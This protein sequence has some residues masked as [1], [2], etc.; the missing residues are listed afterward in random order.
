MD[1]R[2]FRPFIIFVV[3]HYF[4]FLETPKI[5]NWPI[6]YNYH[7]FIRNNWRY[8]LANR[9]FTENSIKGIIFNEATH[10]QRNSI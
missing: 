2:Q 4:I 5:L 10:S 9:F 3:H 6:T 7:L 1:G 8:C